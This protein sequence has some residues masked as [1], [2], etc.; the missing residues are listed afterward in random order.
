M[1]HVLHVSPEFEPSSSGVARH[2]QGLASAA[3]AC[4]DIRLSILAPRLDDVPGPYRLIEGGYRALWKAVGTADV[5]HVH[6]AR[7]PFAAAAALVAWLRGRPMAYTPHCYYDGGTPSRRLLKRLW[8]LSVERALAT[9]AAAMVLLHDGWIADLAK[10][11]IRPRHPLV[12]PNC[13]D[14]RRSSLG[15]PVALEGRP[16]I[17]SIGRLDPVK[18]LDDVIA[19]LGRPGLADAVLHVVGRG[20]D[21]ARLQAR[22]RALGVA[23]RVRFLGWQDDRQAARL[24]AGCDLMVLASE[25]EGLPTVLI[26]ALLT[27]TPVACSDIPGC[28]AVADPV[29]WDALF[30]LGD[31]DALARCLRETADRPVPHEVR[32]RARR[33]FT[34]QSRV[35]ELLTLYRAFGAAHPAG[36]CP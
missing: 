36:G 16:A 20:P 1:I 27:G 2:I 15:E 9:R 28:R 23:D 19:A 12:I 10:R 24:M 35:T 30:A 25:R 21:L 7:M 32:E 4:P 6:G 26:E 34:W 31:L 3:E 33:L 5:V 17:L 8:D 13:V 18:R 11:G 29:G 14:A 22:A